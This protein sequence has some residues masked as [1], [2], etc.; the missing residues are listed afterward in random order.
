M[1]YV[2]EYNTIVSS[3]VMRKLLLKS[4]PIPVHILSR[5]GH[6][7]FLFKLCQTPVQLV[8]RSISTLTEYGQEHQKFI[9]KYFPVHLLLKYCISCSLSK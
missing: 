4:C 6:Y 1:Q 7:L 5:S 8:I 9:R 2:S 3:A